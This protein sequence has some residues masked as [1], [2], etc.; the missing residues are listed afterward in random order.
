MHEHNVVEGVSWHAS[1]AALTEKVGPH[2]RIFIASLVLKDW[3][4]LDL[5]IDPNEHF[6]VNW[7][8]LQQANDLP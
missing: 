3:H 2:W 5:L 8:L 1:I 6:M 4:A 7:K